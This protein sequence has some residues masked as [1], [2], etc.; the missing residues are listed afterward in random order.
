MIGLVLP[1]LLPTPTIRFSLDHKG[2][3]RDEAVSGIGTLLSLDHTLC[4]SDYYSDSD[5]VASEN[6]PLQTVRCMMYKLTS[7]YSEIAVLVCPHKKGNLQ[8]FKKKIHSEARFQKPGFWCPK[9]PLTVYVWTKGY[10]GE[11]KKITVFKNDGM[12]VDEA[13]MLCMKR[14]DDVFVFAIFY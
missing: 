10:N 2:N 9:W 5:S 1:F 14:F 3:V 6:Q 7:S 11:G 12:R 4:A 13:L 8:C